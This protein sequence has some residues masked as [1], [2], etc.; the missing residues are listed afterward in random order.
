MDSSPQKKASHKALL[1]FILKVCDL[2]PAR[3]RHQRKHNVCDTTQISLQ[4][5]SSVTPAW[6]HWNGLTDPEA[7]IHVL[8]DPGLWPL[9]YMGQQGGWR[10]N[11]L[12]LS[13]GHR[14]R[15]PHPDTQGTHPLTPRQRRSS[16]QTD[17]SRDIWRGDTEGLGL[18][19]HT[20]TRTYHSHTHY[21]VNTQVPKTGV[22]LM[23]IVL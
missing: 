18:L 20:H 6:M 8:I 17:S 4:T 7:R 10:N 2:I 21:I 22:G 11:D 14:P 19:L 16:S 13:F 12:Q 5:I 3:K 1:A 15:Q 23:R 9:T